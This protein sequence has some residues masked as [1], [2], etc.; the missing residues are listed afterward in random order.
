VIKFIAVGDNGRTAVG[1]GL[2]YENLRRLKDDQPIR[3]DLTKLGIVGP[4][5][6]VVIFAGETEASMTNQLARSGA[7]GPDTILHGTEGEGA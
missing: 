5:H 7:I 3:V 2:S 1:L 6:E 4:P